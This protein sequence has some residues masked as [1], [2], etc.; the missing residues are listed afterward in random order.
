MYFKAAT[1]TLTL[2]AD[3]YCYHYNLHNISRW[4]SLAH[5]QSSL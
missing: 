3:L 2:F 1:K 4:S 5:C